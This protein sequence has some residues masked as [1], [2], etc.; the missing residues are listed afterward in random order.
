MTIVLLIITGNLSFVLSDLLKLFFKHSV[1]ITHYFF[2]WLVGKLLIS[3]RNLIQRH[4][5]EGQVTYCFE[6][7]FAQCICELSLCSLLYF[8]Q[9]ISRTDFLLQNL[10]NPFVLIM[11]NHNVSLSLSA[12]SVFV[13]FFISKTCLLTKITFSKGRMLFSLSCVDRFHTFFDQF[14]FIFVSIFGSHS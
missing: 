1:K 7:V 5:F 14:T 10:D 2:C 9:I 13:S 4:H 12:N 6:K 8:Y 3:E 11:N